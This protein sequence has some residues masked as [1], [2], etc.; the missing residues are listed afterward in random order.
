M[1]YRTPLLGREYLTTASNRWVFVSDICPLCPLSLAFRF[2]LWHTLNSLWLYLKR[3]KLFNNTFS[4]VEVPLYYNRVVGLLPSWLHPLPLPPSL[5]SS[6]TPV[7]DA[8]HSVTQLH[9]LLENKPPSPAEDLCRMCGS[10]TANPLP[11]IERRVA[12]LGEAF[13]RCSPQVLID[14]VQETLTDYYRLHECNKFC[15]AE[16]V[17]EIRET[18]QGFTSII[19]TYI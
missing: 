15:W 7:S 5:S 4:L 17:E 19:Y 12:S 3:V 16:E 13:L 14:T 9:L 8:T 10:C 2:I 11:D 1:Q 18:G 6:M